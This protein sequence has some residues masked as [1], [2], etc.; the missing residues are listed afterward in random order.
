MKNR[1]ILSLLACCFICS[2]LQMPAN[3]A[4]YSFCSKQLS[5][6]SAEVSTAL[7]AISSQNFTNIN[8]DKAKKYMRHFIE[9]TADYELV[10]NSGGKEKIATDGYYTET[11]EGAKGCYHYADFVANV[12]YEPLYDHKDITEPIGSVTASGLK[13]FLQTNAQAGEHLRF[14]T[15]DYVYGG[16]S[17]VFIS[18]TSS[19]FYTLQYYGQDAPPFFGYSTYEDFAQ[20]INT[21]GVPFW[22]YNAD[23]A[24]NA[25]TS[26]VTVHSH[27]YDSNG[28]C[29][30]CGAEY[31]IGITAVSGGYYVV[32]DN[33]PVRARPYASDKVLSNLKKG[34]VVYVVGKG[35]NSVGNLWYK[36][37]NGNWVFSDNLALAASPACTSHTYSSSGYC[38]KCGKEYPIVITPL[39]GKYSP[40]KD[41]VPVRARPYAAD[42]ILKNL[43]KKDTVTVIGS[44]LNSV[45]NLW[46]KISDGNW[47]F[48][49]NLTAV[50]SPTVTLTPP[51]ATASQASNTTG[52]VSW[53]AVSGADYY[54][55]EY[56][57]PNTNNQW[58]V[59][60][61][62]GNNKATSYTPGNMGNYTYYFHVM[63]A[64]LAGQESGWSNVASYTHVTEAAVTL[65]KVTIKY[66]RNGGDYAPNSHSVA[67]DDSGVVSFTLST[68]KAI[69]SGYTFL[70][71]RLENDTAYG[72]DSPGDR[73]T[74]DTGSATSDTILT[75]Y[76][77]WGTTGYTITY[78]ANGGSGAPPS[79]VKTERESFII[80]SIVPIRDG[81]VFAGWAVG[82]NA[83]GG[84]YEQGDSI[85]ARWG[86]LVLYATWRKI[87][88]ETT[89]PPEVIFYELDS[90][91]IGIVNE[92]VGGNKYKSTIIFGCKFFFQCKNHTIEE[93]GIVLLDSGK[94]PIATENVTPKTSAETYI[95][96]KIPI[97]ETILYSYSYDPTYTGEKQVP[98]L[99]GNHP[100]L[101]NLEKGKNYYWYVYVISDGQRIESDMQSFVFEPRIE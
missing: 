67:K 94:R 88:Q 1:F 86:D 44:G 47:I 41:N 76:A 17:L 42:T 74:F 101:A 20:T 29:N 84:V 3:A 57:S 63:A 77:Q 21:I 10:P 49:D 35:N 9:C 51:R 82:K 28:Y 8:A 87:P 97:Y 2:L 48:S 89:A 85:P 46:Y 12:I 13:S 93:Y 90:G 45:G 23:T 98:E 19:G 24:T 61:D 62:Y 37:S 31:P 72:I 36:L 39:S 70:G 75:Y 81:Y 92:A 33:V 71:W 69:R 78:D 73:I 4:S 80:S 58:V 25:A 38:T 15:V 7:S 18:A 43:S 11:L 16:H 96:Q 68:Q 6:S 83:Y 56:Q 50:A 79:E 59:D 55:V 60:K 26:G 100:I 53:N 52:R 14:S 64:N 27:S 34:A 22:I 54:V 66:N 5:A 30:I 99:I 40:T 32:K 91:W 95:K 65:G